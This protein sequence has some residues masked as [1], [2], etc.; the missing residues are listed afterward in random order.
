MNMIIDDIYMTNVTRI[1]DP[2]AIIIRI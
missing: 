1:D 2:E